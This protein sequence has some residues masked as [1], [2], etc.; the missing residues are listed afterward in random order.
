[1]LEPLEARIRG[2]G[3]RVVPSAFDPADPHLRA[4]PLPAAWRWRTLEDHIKS[5]SPETL[6][7]QV[8]IFWQL[9]PFAYLASSAAGAGICILEPQNYPLT[10]AAVRLASANAIVAEAS[11]AAAIAEHLENT[12]T[13]L[14]PYWVLVHAVDASQWDL[15]SGLKSRAVRAAQEVHLAPG[16]PLLV[17][18]EGI[19]AGAQ[20]SL[21]H[22]SDIFEWGGGLDAPSITNKAPLPFKL[23]GFALPF[24]LEEAGACACGKRLLARAR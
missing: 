19:V 17:Q 15:P 3:W 13:E 6:V 11:E 1:M 5:F 20:E 10:K 16:V 7:L 14:P 4:L 21:Y 24:S 18:C 2:E 23:E 9:E 22:R 12:S 8:P